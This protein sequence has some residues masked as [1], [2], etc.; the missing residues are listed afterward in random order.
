[1]ERY[2]IFNSGNNEERNVQVNKDYVES[3]TEILEVNPERYEELE[4]EI[5][6]N[7]EY[8]LKQEREIK[9]LLEDNKVS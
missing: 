6:K 7:K 3:L 4:V 8:K 5:A 1:M 9:N 2:S